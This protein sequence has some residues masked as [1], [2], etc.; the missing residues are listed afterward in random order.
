VRRYAVQRL[1]VNGRQHLLRFAAA[2][3]VDQARG[4]GQEWLH[5]T[6]ICGDG[7]AT[8]GGLVQK[9]E[10]FADPALVPG[11]HGLGEQ[12]RGDGLAVVLPRHGED[13]RGH[14]FSR[15]MSWRAGQRLQVCRQGFIAQARWQ[16]RLGEYRLGLDP[17]LL[18][19]AVRAQDRREGAAEPGFGHRRHW[20]R[21]PLHND[22]GRLLEPPGSRESLGGGHRAG[23]HAGIVGMGQVQRPPGQPGCGLRR[24]GQELGCRLV[25]SGQRH[26]VPQAGGFEQMPG[27]GRGGFPRRSRISP[28]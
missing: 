28:N 5:M 12:R 14:P 9:L 8:A 15:L 26:V 3:Q 21:Q 17:G 10:A 24:R 25:Q 27:R 16:F 2:S 20:L 4:E 19:L 18:R 13:A 22:A 7:A 23:Q 1:T 11:D 6:G